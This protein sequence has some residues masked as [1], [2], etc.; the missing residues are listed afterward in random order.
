LYSYY[1]GGLISREELLNVIDVYS[2]SKLLNYIRNI[3]A[4]RLHGT[5]DEPWLMKFYDLS[6]VYW[7]DIM[8]GIPYVMKNKYSLPEY[9]G[10]KLI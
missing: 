2:V 9:F 4:Y 10:C 6:G 3:L 1:L 7:E 5:E 8:S